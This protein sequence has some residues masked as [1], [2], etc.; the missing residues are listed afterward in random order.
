MQQFG[1]LMK[2]SSNSELYDT[3]LNISEN[4]QFT[5]SI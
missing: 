3:K 5:T 1:M 2:H 4:F